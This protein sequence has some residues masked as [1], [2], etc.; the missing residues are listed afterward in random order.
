MKPRQIVYLYS[1]ICLLAIASCKKNDLLNQLPPTSLAEASYWHTTN[2]LQNYMNN[3]YGVDGIFPH[4][5]GY[6]NL[7]IYSVDDN[8]DNMVPQ[9]VNARLNGQL[10]VAGNGGYADW[11]NIRNVNYFL[12]N[13]KKVTASAS[14]VAPYLGE[15]YF[16]RAILYFQAVQNRGAMPWI[17]KPLDLTDTALINAPRL[18]RDIV[19][20]SIVNDL[21][22]A[23]AYLPTKSSAQTQR[24]YKEYA[25]GYKARVC[26]Y[27][28]TWEK[29]HAGD[30]FGVAGQNGA[31]FLQMAA[32]A[33]NLVITSGIYQ[34]DN[35]GVPNGYFNL[36]N[37]TDYS[38]S[39]EIMFWGAYNQQANITTDWQ[40]YYQ[41]GSSGTNSDGISK[42][43]VDD[44]L[45]NDGNP[46]SISR[47]YQGDDSL[48]HVLKNRDPR[49]RQIVFFYGDTVISNMPGANPIKRFTY[50]ALVSGTPCTTGYQIRKGLSTDFFQDV[51]NGP[52]GTTG[53][54]YMRYA[55]ILLTY[56]EARA[57]L[58]LINQNDV[59]ITINK[60]RDRVKMPHLNIGNIIPD[61]KWA[62]PQLS[63]VINEVRRERR[64]ELAC[65]G[66]RL[67]D[68][69]RW[70]A[71]PVLI[72]GKQP[73]G[74]MAKQFLTV[75][76]SLVVGKNIYVNP[77][78]Y[79]QPYTNVSSMANGYNFN[80][81]R[82][83]LLPITLQETTVNPKIKQNP[84]W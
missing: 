32:D 46:I 51:H 34:L 22:K 29:Y 28:G 21:N 39:K 81:N 54:I 35:V 76:P 9:T 66:Y 15:A 18:S 26:L 12:A 62:F 69:C 20:D 63:P 2:D 41:F 70:A 61:P 38:S 78:G 50:P 31:N 43:L 3:L 8:S 65:E 67:N 24:L 64:V 52:G 47:N 13:Y 27:E 36:F 4:Y 79:I 5:L 53:T 57:E 48:A 55:E 84:G 19:V 25:E 30:V 72:V 75:I 56:A 40:N 33:A 1:M 44:Y 60:L 42:S 80:V 10:T 68:I 73:L 77:Q 71:A 82:D 17:N 16:F 83:Y 58:G 37:Q 59:D 23:I 45:C 49:L 74:A 7:G 6:N 14:S 11:T